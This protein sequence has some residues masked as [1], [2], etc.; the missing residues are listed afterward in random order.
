LIYINLQISHFDNKYGTFVLLSAVNAMKGDTCG[1]ICGSDSQSNG[2][3]DVMNLICE[4]SEDISSQLHMGVMKASRKVVLDGIIGDIIA[5][6][7]TEKKSKKQKLESADQT[8]ETCTLNNKL[9]TF[10]CLA[11]LE[12]L[13]FCPLC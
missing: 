1:T 4:I 7:I 3:G 8:S 9:V 6:F 12:N 5:E 11:V 10:T 13:K 2:V